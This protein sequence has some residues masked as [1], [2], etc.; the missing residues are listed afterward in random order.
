MSELT[1]EQTLARLIEVKNERMADAQSDCRLAFSLLND[2]RKD[3]SGIE[4]D[5]Y[6]ALSDSLAAVMGAFMTLLEAQKLEKYWNIE[7]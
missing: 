7:T 4:D 5:H 3:F 6:I 1:R 2:L